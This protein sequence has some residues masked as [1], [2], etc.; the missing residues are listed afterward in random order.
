MI[1]ILG[2]GPAGLLA[3][4]AAERAEREVQI[5]SIKVPSDI[6]GA[7]FLHETIPGLT[8][9][10]PDIV[11]DFQK[12]GTKA[13]YARKIYGNPK[14]PCSWDGYDGET[15]GWDIIA[16]YGRLW[17]HFDSRIV[18]AEVRYPDIEQMIL[19]SD[20]EFV[21]STLNPMGYCQKEHQ[22]EWQRVYISEQASVE[23]EN[24]VVYNGDP[25]VSWYRSARIGD[26][27]S[28]ESGEHIEPRKFHPR[29]K[30]LFTDCDCLEEYGAF[31]KTGRFG[32]FKK[33]VLVHDAYKDT[34][35]TLK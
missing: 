25:E 29:S 20:T 7:Q 12:V 26:H 13:E 21:I 19:A 27:G 2:A 31:K 17:E 11:L 4:W 34:R 6:R 15:P 23:S 5:H 9:R 1:H 10:K 30:P 28:T 16:M 22:F 14:A 33:G 32:A 3:A 24:T 18:D 35:S 8:D